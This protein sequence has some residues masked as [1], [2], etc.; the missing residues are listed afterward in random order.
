MIVL[1][2]FLQRCFAHPFFKSVEESHFYLFPFLL[3]FRKRLLIVFLCFFIKERKHFLLTLNNGGKIQSSV[4]LLFQPLQILFYKFVIFLFDICV[5][6]HLLARSPDEHRRTSQILL[7]ISHSGT[8]EF[9][10]PDGLK[11]AGHFLMRRFYVH[12]FGCFAEL[13]FS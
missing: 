8:P 12:K 3:Q 6:I 2:H 10:L 7:F 13:T 1:L 5:N 4:I 11:S 9:F